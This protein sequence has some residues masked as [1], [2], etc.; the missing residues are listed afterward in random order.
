MTVASIT[1]THELDVDRPAA[2]V[3]AVLADMDRLR[4]LVARA[5]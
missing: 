3:W 1:I 4:R 5:R 2:E